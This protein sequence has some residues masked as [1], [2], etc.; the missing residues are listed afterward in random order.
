M[1][2]EAKN[3]KTQADFSK[4]LLKELENDSNCYGKLY[5]ATDSICNGC[6]DSL[7]CSVYTLR[8]LNTVALKTEQKGKFL[9]LQD[10]KK[11]PTDKLSNLIRDKG[12]CT[13]KQV[14]KVIEH[15]AVT[16]DKPAAMRF[17][18]TFC[19]DNKLTIKN[20]SVYGTH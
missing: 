4:P 6:S 19:K 13:V 18:V 12:E 16:K 14:L 17:L 8:N 11:V 10:F 1:G 15:Y 2:R 5:D 9:D 7:T 3:S 20:G